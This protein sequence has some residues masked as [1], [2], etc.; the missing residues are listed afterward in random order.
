LE[1]DAMLRIF[2]VIGFTLIASPALADAIDGDWCGGGKHLSIKGPQITLPSG[3]SM[4]GQYRRHE[5]AYKIP[6]GDV[7]AGQVIYMHVL[8]DEEMNL[9]HVKDNKPGAPETWKRCEVTS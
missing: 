1:D 2:A 3:A 4:Q 5:F 7:D 6:A 9:Y 8:S